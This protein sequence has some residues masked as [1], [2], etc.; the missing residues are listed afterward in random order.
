MKLTIK[1]IQEA[2][3]ANLRMIATTK[4]SGA[5]GKTVRDMTVLL[6][7]YLV[8]VTHVDTGAYRASHRGEIE[9]SGKP[10]AVISPDTAAINPRSGQAVIKYAPHEEA[11]GDT[12]A[13]YARTFEYGKG[14]MGDVASRHFRI[15]LTK[16]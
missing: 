3:E 11:R 9:M 2:Q 8:T 14:V 12:H 15:S 1:G 16:R 6:H 10:R 7:R 13:A 4:P 5:L